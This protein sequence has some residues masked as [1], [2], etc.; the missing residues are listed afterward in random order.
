M[1]T[2]ENGLNLIKHYESIHDGDLS[3]MG[4][5]PKQDPAGIWTAGWGHALKDPSGKWITEFSDIKKYHPEFLNID[6]LFAD[7]LLQEDVKY[8][9]DWLNAQE[10]LIQNEFDA[11]VSFAFNCGIGA[12][13]GS[14]LWKRVRACSESDL[15]A[16]AFL[17]WNKA[18]GKVL[19]GLTNRR[20]TEA[21][22]YNN[23]LII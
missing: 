4:L 21:M 8:V 12:L 14:T 9:E 19:N 2:S 16:E 20:R 11:L 5:Q 1:K 23:C 13:S 18:G 6:E 15:I 17:M 7:A 22:L 3:Q 10:E